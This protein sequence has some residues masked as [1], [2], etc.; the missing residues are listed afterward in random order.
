MTP[1]LF[2]IFIDGIVTGLGCNT[3][4]TCTS[5]F[6]Y[7]DD[8]MLNSPSVSMLQTMLH[9]CESELLDLDMSLNVTKF[10]CMR[11]GPVSNATCV[12]LTTH[13]GYLLAGVGI[14]SY[15]GVYFSSART[16]KSCLD[17]CKSSFFAHLTPSWSL[18]FA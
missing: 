14:C 16:Y 11:F 10:V 1:C 8:I 13:G 7:A 2:A 17:N 9:L 4:L 3:I 6:L 12:N 18:C 15:L 5:I